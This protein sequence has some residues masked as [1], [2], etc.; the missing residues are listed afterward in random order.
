[1]THKVTTPLTK[2]GMLVF[3]E[4][5]HGI[6]RAN[7]EGVPI[8]NIREER[9]R[10]VTSDAS[11]EATQGSRTSLPIQRDWIDHIVIQEGEHLVRID[12]NI[13]M[14][15]LNLEDDKILLAVK[16]ISS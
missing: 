6:L 3:R 10:I 2:D 1:M 7:I 12:L 16:I 8:F 5:F 14:L 13:T 9:E 15:L 4:C 11:S